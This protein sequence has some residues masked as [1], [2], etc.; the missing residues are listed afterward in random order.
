VPSQPLV[1]LTMRL[2]NAKTLQFE[3]FYGNKQP[4][5]AV[6]SHRWEK[7]EEE[8]RC[9]DILHG[10]RKNTAGYSKIKACCELAL[11]ESLEYVWV[12]TC[13]IDKTNS[14]EFQEAINSMFK[15]YKNSEVCYAYLSDYTVN[16]NQG[17]DEELFKESLWF[18]RGWTLQELIAPAKVVF[19]CR[20][21][22]LIGEKT[23]ETICNLI[24]STTGINRKV[25]ASGDLEKC[26]IAERMSWASKR[27][28]TR[29][30]DIA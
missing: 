1:V 20:D 4:P 19:F 15:W 13:C 23:D 17:L 28:T 24:S 3:T 21:W 22:K 9:Q 18:S 25:L 6:L 16:K 14:V 29:H 2:L 26:S 30:E 12:D 27:S 5:Y 8:L 7:R 11:K 10:T